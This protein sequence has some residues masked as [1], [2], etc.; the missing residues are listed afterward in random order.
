M[1]LGLSVIACG[2]D[3]D[4]GNGRTA[5][6]SCKNGCNKLDS[7]GLSSSGFSCDDFC[8]EGGCAECLNTRSCDDITGGQCATACPNA[9]FKPKK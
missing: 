7:C 8:P 1:L 2:D 6:Q 5:A 4:D 9:S 3:D